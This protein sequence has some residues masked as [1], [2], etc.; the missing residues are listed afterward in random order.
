VVASGVENAG[1]RVPLD[2]FGAS[3]QAMKVIHFAPSIHHDYASTTADMKTAA[4]IF[5]A[6]Y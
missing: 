2:P 5:E 3:F 1:E 4:A 6:F